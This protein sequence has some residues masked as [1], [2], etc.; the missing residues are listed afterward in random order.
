MGVSERVFSVP[1]R[2]FLSPQRDFLSPQRD[3]LS[4]QR[5]FLCT[6]PPGGGSKN[7]VYRGFSPVGGQK[8]S[9]LY[10]PNLYL[11]S[12]EWHSGSFL[13]F[14]KSRANTH[15]ISITPKNGSIR[16]SSFK[17]GVSGPPPGGG[18]KRSFLTPDMI[19]RQHSHF[20]GVPRGGVKNT[21][22]FGFSGGDEKAIVLDVHTPPRG[23]GYCEK[24]V[25]F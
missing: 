8:V 10:T 1:Q 19:L 24:S 7:T 5:D 12:P 11:L 2:N 23:G 18:S 3:F 15:W 21:P 17:N 9:F 13:I 4:P 16:A 14:K 20:L 25:F 6:P 22:F